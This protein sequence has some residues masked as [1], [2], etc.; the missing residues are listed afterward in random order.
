MEEHPTTAS[1]RSPKDW[2]GGRGRI[3]AG[4]VALTKLYDEESAD[5]KSFTSDKE[6]NHPTG[7]DERSL[8]TDPNKICTRRDPMDLYNIF[9]AEIPCD[10]THAKLNNTV[11]S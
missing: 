5:N 9:D 4:P 2:Q 3:Q 6:D 10:E 7:P 1:K 8:F 11:Y